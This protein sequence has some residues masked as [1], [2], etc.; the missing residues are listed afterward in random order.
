MKQDLIELYDDYTH[1]DMS[2]REFLERLSALAGGTAAALSLL[3]VLENDY[4]RAETLNPDDT[5][6]ETADIEFKGAQGMIRA[7]LAK[8]SELTRKIPAVLV[9]H[10]NKGLHPHIKDVTRRVA[11]EGFLAMAPD[12]LSP[13]GGTPADMDK[14]RQMFRRLDRGKTLGD[15]LAAVDFLSRQKASDGNVGSVGF[16]WGGGMANRLAVASPRMKAAVAFYGRQP[17]P[18]DVP[19]IKGSLLLHYAGLDTRIN[20]GIP[21]FRKALD[22][23][24]TD[25]GL[26]IYEGVNHAFHNDTNAARYDEKAAKLAWNRT[27]A[28]LRSKLAAAPVNGR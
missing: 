11:S 9:I 24:G 15:F 22:A 20:R 3:L 7:Y 19:K 27:I 1:G 2:R 25:Y 18:A 23:A 12:A 5:R 21:E 8:P 6:I 10:E 17:D 26:F 14:A 13:L 28:F 4:T 16:C